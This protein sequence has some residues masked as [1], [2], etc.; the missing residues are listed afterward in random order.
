MAEISQTPAE[1]SVVK[2]RDIFKQ[3]ERAEDPLKG[4]DDVA[5]FF[6]KASV[7][8]PL[9]YKEGEL[10]VLLTK[11]SH[12][13]THHAGYVAFPGG[14]RDDTD[15]DDIETALRESDEEIGLRPCDVEVIGVF[16]P[17]FVRPNSLVTPVIGL[18]SPDFIPVRNEKE[19][20]FVF[21]LPLKRFL[22]DERR[23]VKDFQMDSLEQK[24]FHVY[25]F[26]DTVHGEEV[27]TWGFTA[28]QCMMVALIA[29]QSDKQ[30]NF[31]EDIVVTKDTAHKGFYDLKPFLSK[32]KIK[33][34]L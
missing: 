16:C 8:I 28:S 22:N 3:F 2:L 15:K 11:R 23:T 31:V 29:L 4:L 9:F 30:F 20:A 17:G 18:I 6:T 1:D 14:K 5:S 26:L 32:F 13:L 12:E 25:H 27:D 19:V 34:S 7:L 21:D 24:T 33:P 10:H